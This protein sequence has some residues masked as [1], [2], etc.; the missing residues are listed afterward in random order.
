MPE[1]TQLDRIE[2][3]LARIEQLLSNV[4]ALQRATL[5]E[6]FTMASNVD[7][8]IAKVTELET[9]NDS[10][11]ALLGQLA[12]LIRDNSTDQTALLALADR[13]DQDKTKM[14][15]A[16]VANTPSGPTT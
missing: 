13:I 6:I 9:V 4:T 8:V 15:D 3:R 7:T 1:Q 2:G 14:A 10:A 16:V 11:I 12:Q 5:S